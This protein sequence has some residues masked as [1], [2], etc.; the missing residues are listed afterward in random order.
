MP[1]TVKVEGGCRASLEPQSFSLRQGS[2]ERQRKMANSLLGGGRTAVRVFTGM[3]IPFSGFCIFCC[4]L[5]SV[6]FWGGGI[7]V[8]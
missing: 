5:S 6:L 3:N 8:T 7:G 4:L 1:L 2:A